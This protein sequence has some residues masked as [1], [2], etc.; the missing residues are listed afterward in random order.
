MQRKTLTVAGIKTAGLDDGE[1]LGW[2]STWDTDSV[3]D[4][5]M[6]GAFAKSIADMAA[7]TVVPI[8]WEHKTDDPRN[9]VGEIKSAR[10]TPEGLEIHAKLDVDTEFGAAAYRAVR[11]RRVSALSI[12][13]GIRHA[14]KAADG[15]QELT[16]LDLREV[17]LVSRPANERA[18]ITASKSQPTSR[19]KSWLA[20]RAADTLLATKGTTTMTT[21][22]R[23]E[24]LTKSR[25]QQIELVTQIVKAADELQRDLTGEE[26]EQV[27]AATA[28]ATDLDKKLKAAVADEDAISDALA[29]AK[30]IGQP[31]RN[32]D[33]DGDRP[34]TGHLP[35]T[36]KGAKSL[37][38]SIAR[39]SLDPQ[40][41][42][43]VASGARTTAVELRSEIAEQGRPPTSLLDVLA[44]RITGPN[45]SYMRQNARVNAAAPVAQGAVKPTSAPTLETIDAK[46]TVVAHISEQVDNYVVR[47][48]E[49]IERFLEDEMLWGLRAAVENQIING[50]GTAPNLRGLLNTSGIQSQGFATDVLTSVRKGLTK[51][52]ALGYS[53]GVLAVSPGDWEAIELLATTSGAT[54]VR[55][56]PIDA[57]TR[58][59][60]GV[61]AV[62]SAVLPAKTAVLLD[63]SAVSVDTDGQI[64]T[65]WSDAVGDD[66]ERNYVRCR[67]EGRYGLS[68]FRPQGIVSIATAAA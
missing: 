25:D 65:R 51:L 40:T 28:K 23:I 13:Y 43:L 39:S 41:K 22:A 2:A 7:G 21:T 52:E 9:L 17:S 5:V 42:A 54:D 26:A 29:L 6:P 11:G 24:A 3:G 14:T 57:V 55:G 38:R 32:G 61:Q 66:F 19:S 63:G 48:N 62:V 45:Y 49:G 58:R 44:S 64:D 4:R 12:G 36:G 50:S 53:P 46:L 15:V 16:D 56:V 8:A 34:K 60:F 27:Q 47:D 30:S 37:A 10:E 31:L 67:V 18:L 33:D 35:L 68:V 59:L 20:R 1:F